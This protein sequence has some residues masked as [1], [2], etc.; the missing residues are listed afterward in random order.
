MYVIGLLKSLHSS[1]NNGVRNDIVDWSLKII[2]AGVDN[3]SKTEFMSI[4]IG[5]MMVAF[6]SDPRTL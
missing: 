4:R 1:E 2:H 3:L 6:T 5:L